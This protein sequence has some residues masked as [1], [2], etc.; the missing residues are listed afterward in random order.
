MSETE[1]RK[2]KKKKRQSLLEPEKVDSELMP[3]LVDALSELEKQRKYV[4]IQVC[5]H[6]KSPRVRRVNSMKGDMSAHM[7]LTPP[8]YECLECGWRERTVMKA[9][10]RPTT[11]R[12]VVI[13]A[14]AKDAEKKTK[15]QEH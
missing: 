14:E 13:M 4:D 9:T 5:P 12:D 1:Q 7:G 10:N 2:K 15:Q 3:E 8:K 11:V 6:C